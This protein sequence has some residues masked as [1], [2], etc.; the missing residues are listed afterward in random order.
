MVDKLIESLLPIVEE[1]YGRAGAKFGLKNNSDH[2][3]Y[4]VMKE[5]FEEAEDEIDRLEDMLDTFW[6]CVKGND[7]PDQ[8]LYFCK[9]IKNIA[10]LAACECIQVA[11]MA[12]KAAITVCDGPAYKELIGEE[13]NA[14]G[15]VDRN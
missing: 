1:E 15:C 3:S 14:D 13:E 9:R 7:N 5:E 11:A 10:V 4:A 8:K 6:A 2:E 12:H